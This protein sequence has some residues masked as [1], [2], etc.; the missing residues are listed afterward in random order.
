MRRA[1]RGLLV[2]GGFAVIVVVTALVVV[3]SREIPRPAV[4]DTAGATATPSATGSASPALPQNPIAR[5]SAALRQVE[6]SAAGTGGVLAGGCATLNGVAVCVPHVTVDGAP[7]EDVLILEAMAGIATHTGGTTAPSDFAIAAALTTT[8]T[9]QVAVGD[10]VDEELLY[11]EGLKNAP[12]NAMQM[13]TTIAGQQLQLYLTDPS[14]ATGVIPAG[15]TPQEFYLSP[16]TVAVYE[17]GLILGHEKMVLASAGTDPGVWFRQE[18]A[19]HSVLI[20]GATPSFSLADA[21]QIP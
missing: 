16:S 14:G 8:A 20:D 6:T 12:A 7:V 21:A 13:A 4:A 19:S 9:E 2:R 18:L 17:R 3:N 1:I 10:A 15:M 11:R 5:W